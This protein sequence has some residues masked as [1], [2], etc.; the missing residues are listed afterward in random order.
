M[1]L[2]SNRSFFQGLIN[3]KLTTGL[4]IL[5]TPAPPHKKKK[6][7]AR[8]INSIFKAVRVSSSQHGILY[9]ANHSCW[10]TMKKEILSGAARTENAAKEILA[11][12]GDQGCALGRLRDAGGLQ[13]RKQWLADRRRTIWEIQAWV[14]GTAEYL[15]VVQVCE[16]KQV[17]RRRPPFMEAPDPRLLSWFFLCWEVSAVRCVC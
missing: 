14:S 17:G 4:L 5:S 16:E 10:M 11:E 15:Q 3:D 2:K 7:K 13:R 9:S 12:T 8:E 6:K 1:D